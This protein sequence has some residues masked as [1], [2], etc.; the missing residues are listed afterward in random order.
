MYWYRLLDSSKKVFVPDTEVKGNPQDFFGSENIVEWGH[1]REKDFV[2]DK[3]YNS[4]EKRY[5]WDMDDIDND[6]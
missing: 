6:E 3:L 5:D 2:I 1:K 4:L